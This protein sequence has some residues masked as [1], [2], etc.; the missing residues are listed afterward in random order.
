MAKKPIIISGSPRSGSTWIGR[1]LEV[2][3]DTA[4]IHEP[5][6]I[7]IKRDNSPFKFWMEGVFEEQSPRHLSTVKTYFDG[8]YK[9]DK[10]FLKQ[11]F[12][13]VKGIS[14]LRDFRWKV[15]ERNRVTTVI[16]DPLAFFAIDW[17]SK[18]ISNTIIITV[19][20]PAAVVASLKQK[21]WGYDFSQMLKQPIL[22]EKY[23]DCYREEIEEFAKSEKSLVEQGAL[24]W[25][26]VY[27]TNI[28]LMQKHK[29]WLIV[30]NEDLSLDPLKEYERIF[31]Y[32]KL[33]FD[34]K[35]KDYLVA[36]T[37]AKSGEESLLV[38]D[39][40]KNVG[41]WKSLL[42]E[43]EIA[44]IKSFTEEVWKNYYTEKDW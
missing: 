40:K 33:P 23:L 14:T 18:N 9:V 1:V 5:F 7:G 16:K 22:M 41:K 37:N 2:H 27:E 30:K 13:A 11:E 34:Q 42:N 6:N 12:K 8:F 4:Y 21:K 39:S 19:R 38:R 44:Y 17:I 31:N 43:D 29:Y 3:P 15:K 25:K 35:V 28:T 26:C 36:S 24:L 10:R 20:H 32:I